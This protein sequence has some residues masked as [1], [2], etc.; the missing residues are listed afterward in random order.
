MFG[1]DRCLVFFEFW[2]FGGKVYIV[3]L[4]IFITVIVNTEKVF[5]MGFFKNMSRK[6]KM[7]ARK[8]KSFRKQSNDELRKLIDNWSDYH[9]PKRSFHFF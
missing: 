8:G 5:D 6:E 2:Y 3:L 4:L 9:F 7:L 1:V